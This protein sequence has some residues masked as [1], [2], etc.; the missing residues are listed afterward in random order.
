MHVSECGARAMKGWEMLFTNVV[1]PLPISIG[2]LIASML[3]V[4]GSTRTICILV[5]CSLPDWYEYAI[6]FSEIKETSRWYISL[7]PGSRTM[8]FVSVMSKLLIIST[9]MAESS[10]EGLPAGRF[11]G[12]ARN[13]TTNEFGLKETAEISETGK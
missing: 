10:F 6:K 12:I 7:R 3:W 5:F 13:A 11:M 2:R 8:G 1:G 4:L 9:Y